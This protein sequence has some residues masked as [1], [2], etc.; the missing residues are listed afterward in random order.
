MDKK[1]LIRKKF[2]LLRKK[3]YFEVKDSYFTPIIK[4]ISKFK[5]DRKINVS[6]YYPSF[7]EVNVLKIFDQDFSKNCNFFLPIIEKNNKMQFHEWKKNDILFVN[8]YGLL[9]PKKSRQ[10]VPDVV[11]VP[12]LSFDKNK[13]RIGYGKGYYDKYLN[14]YVKSNKKILT[15]G[16]AFSFQK[17]HKLPVNHKDF[18]LD[19]V[20]TEKGVIK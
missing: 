4:I 17:Y 12:I 1:W 16:V 7:Y 14:K 3:N 8:K 10:I 2:F 6:I 11:L 20:I 5:I 18:K 19:F 9:E 15:I 13:N